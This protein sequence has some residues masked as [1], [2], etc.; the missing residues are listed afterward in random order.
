MAAVK[1]IN[2][3]LGAPIVSVAVAGAQWAKAGFPI[4]SGADLVVRN[5]VIG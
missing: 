2:L 1:G 4:V 3:K 5:G